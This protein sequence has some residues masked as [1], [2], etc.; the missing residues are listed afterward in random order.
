MTDCVSCK[1]VSLS[2]VGEPYPT[3]CGECGGT[4]VLTYDYLRPAGFSVDAAKPDLGRRRYESASRSLAGFTSAAQLLVGVNAV[5]GGQTNPRISRSLYSRVHVGD[6]FMRNMGSGESGVGFIIC[7]TCGR[8]LDPEGER[9]HTYPADVPPHRG[10]ARGPRA[11]DTCP[12]RSPFDNRVV[13][14]HNFR[15]EVILL[16]FD[17]PGSLDAPFMEPSGKAVW[18]FVRRTGWRRRSQGSA[19]QP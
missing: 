8:A 12:N 14:G 2:E 11:G 18:Y 10:Y 7:R 4:N 15:S 16:A 5:E 19:N 1:A 13:L 3:E 9:V 17:L 6:L